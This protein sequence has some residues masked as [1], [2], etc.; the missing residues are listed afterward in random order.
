MAIDFTLTPEQS[1][2]KAD[3]RKFANDVLAGVRAATEP[4]PTAEERFLATRPTYEAMVAAGY[5]RKCIPAPASPDKGG[6]HDLMASLTGQASIFGHAI[7]SFATAPGEGGGSN[8][9]ADAHVQNPVLAIPHSH[10]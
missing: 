6:N 2:L 5:L 10:A 1:A 9:I 4:L 7:A 8:V 3:A